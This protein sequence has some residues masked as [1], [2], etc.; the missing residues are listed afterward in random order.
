MKSIHDPRYVEM[1]SHLK[2]VRKS[3][4][5]SQV[6][7]GERLRRDQKYVSKVESLVRRLDL[8]ELCDWLDALEYNMEVFLIE[9]GRLRK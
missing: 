3:K 2:Q 9:I 7:L 1:I 6:E 8:I 4:K 5:V